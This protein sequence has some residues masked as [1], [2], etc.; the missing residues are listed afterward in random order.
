MSQA[1]VT[2]SRE[3]GVGIIELSRPDKF[4]ALS[5][6]SMALITEALD[7]FEPDRNVRAVLLRAQGKNFSTGHDLE[8]IHASDYETNDLAESDALVGHA[9]LNRL[10]ASRLPVV[11]AVQG[12]CL[13]G[14]L[15]LLLACDVVLAAASARLGDQ[16]ARYGLIPGWGG[17]QRL[18]RLVGLRRSLDLFFSARWLDAATAEQ[19]G[20]VNRVVDDAALQTEALAYCH[21]LAQ[22]NPD[23]LELMKRLA[24][25]G[26]DAPLAEGLAAEV[27]TIQHFGALPNTQEGV[28][29]FM[30][31]REPR[32]Q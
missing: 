30:E 1:H 22:R 3:G 2:I 32:F 12:L 19:W 28:A 27:Q 6:R 14:G 26:L 4:N 17:S 10:E 16:H 18:P 5:R 20:L 7:T 23:S 31:R 21:L 29:A 11:A 24:R 8:E 15:E 25:Q 13:A 9:A